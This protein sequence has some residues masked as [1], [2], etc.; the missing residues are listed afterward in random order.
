MQPAGQNLHLTSPLT[1]RR[2]RIWS[3]FS[4]K[5]SSVYGSGPSCFS[6][7][8]ELG[9]LLP[10]LACSLRYSRDRR[11][12]QHAVR[13]STLVPAPVKAPV[14]EISAVAG[15]EPVSKSANVHILCSKHGGSMA[16]SGAHPCS[17]CA[18]FRSAA[19][20]RGLGSAAPHMER[21]AFNYP[22]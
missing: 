15:A 8:L 10:A 12:N 16:C 7:A 3:L 17:W 2:K 20:K 5:S 4:N 22:L 21:L 9:Y 14:D 11:R 1:A 6:V 19:G 18:L 13:F